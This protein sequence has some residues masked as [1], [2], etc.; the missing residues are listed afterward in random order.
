[1]L[2]PIHDHVY[3]LQGKKPTRFPYCNCLLI[4]DEVRTI[5][6]TGLEQEVILESKPEQIELI[7]NS[8]G[9]GDHINGNRAFPRAQVGIHRL[10]ADT[11]LSREGFADNLGLNQ[12]AELCQFR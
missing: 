7:L 1:M 2:I 3:L 9:H 8:H 5:I 12:W 10:E 4:E 11:V 6:D